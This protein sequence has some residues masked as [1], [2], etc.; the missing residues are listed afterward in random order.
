MERQ[1]VAVLA[2]DVVGYSRMMHDDEVGTFEELKVRRLTLFEPN[3]RSYR[4][5][6]VKTMGDGLLVEF[7]SALDAVNCAIALQE[8][9]QVLDASR[10]F[11]RRNAK[12]IP[13]EGE[14]FPSVQIP[15]EIRFFRQV[16][17]ARLDRHIAR[18]APE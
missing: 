10:P 5:R 3:L 15:V 4:G 17:D 12:K 11:G 1:L 8:A 6:L 14:R 18:R 7:G 13:K 2:A 9:N 16:A